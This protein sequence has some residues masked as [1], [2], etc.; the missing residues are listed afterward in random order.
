MRWTGHGA[1]LPL[2]TRT[3]KPVS[4]PSRG[5]LIDET[6]NQRTA[7]HQGVILREQGK[8]TEAVRVF[9]TLLVSDATPELK[10][11][12]VTALNEIVVTDKN[13]KA[14]V[15]VAIFRFSHEP[16]QRRMALARLERMGLVEPL[17]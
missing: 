12:V 14:D 5:L 11:K 7:Y 4:E 17:L 1:G 16:E 6:W 9:Q 8:L 15:L 2:P 10:A 13:L 3:A